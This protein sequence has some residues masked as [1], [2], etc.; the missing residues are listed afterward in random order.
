MHLWLFNALYLRPGHDQIVIATQRCVDHQG[1]NDRKGLVERHA[2]VSHRPHPS[3]LTIQYALAEQRAQKNQWYHRL[4]V[5]KEEYGCMVG[6]GLTPARGP[7]GGG[8]PRPYHTSVLL[9][10]N[11]KAVIPLIFLSTLLRESILDSENR[12]V[13]SVRDV[14]VSL[15]E[16]FPVITALVVYTSLGGNNDLIVPWS[17]VQSIEEPEV[18]LTVKQDQVTPY[19]PHDNELMLRRDILDKQIVDT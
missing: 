12:R 7:T 8:Q 2:Y 6:A 15:D 3:I 13:G 4:P 17:Q 1:R 16:T 10:T 9:F 11:G 18:H 5:C 19:I 14:C